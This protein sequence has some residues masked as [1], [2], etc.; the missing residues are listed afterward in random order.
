MTGY[1]DF[2]LACEAGAI[3]VDGA[4]QFAHAFTVHG[5]TVEVDRHDPAQPGTHRGTL[6]PTH[7]FRYGERDASTRQQFGLLFLVEE[8]RNELYLLV[9]SC[10]LLRVDRIGPGYQ[11]VQMRNLDPFLARLDKG[12]RVRY[13]IV[14]SPTKRL[15]RSD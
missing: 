14:A 5:T 7:L 9:Q 2:S 11:G 15:G 6:R 1:L 13:R 10:S 12:S 4:V 3:E 8:A